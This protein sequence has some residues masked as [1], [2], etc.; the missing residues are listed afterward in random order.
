[1]NSALPLP[2][3]QSTGRWRFDW[4]LPLI[5]RPRRALAA[6][7]AAESPVWQAPVAILLLGALVRTLVDGSVRQ[8]L[9]QMQGPVLPQGFEYYTPEQ[10]AQFMQALQATSGPVFV[11]VLPAVL[12]LLGVLLGWLLI[13]GVLYLLLT[14][15]GDRRSAVQTRNLVAWALLPFI[16][17]DLLR[18]GALWTSGQPLTYLGLSGFA[19]PPDANGAIFLGALLAAV[20]IYLL[21]HAGLLVAGVHAGGALSRRK[22][23]LVVVATLLSLYLLRAVPAVIA[24]QF[25]DL[26]VI[27]PFF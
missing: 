15:A 3:P 8:A 1:M 2:L 25:S 14:L 27:R 11:Y 21:W 24:A 9:A 16:F 18:I 5:F 12:S 13:S 22:G 7:T 10:Q 17:R 19:P 26:T 6:I 20:D 23:W 4:L